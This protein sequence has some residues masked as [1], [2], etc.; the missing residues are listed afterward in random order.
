MY[1]YDYANDEYEL[2]HHHK[3]KHHGLEITPVRQTRKTRRI[4]KANTQSVELPHMEDDTHFRRVIYNAKKNVIRAK[5]KDIEKFVR[6]AKAKYSSVDLKL[7]QQAF[8]TNQLASGVYKVYDEEGYY[9]CTGTLVSGRMYV[10][11]HV[12][13]EDTTKHY[14]ARNHVHSIR[15]EAKDAY[16]V[17]NEVVAFKVNG[18]PSV[19]TNK[20]FKKL[21]DSGI[22][23]IFGFGNG[24]SSTP[25]SIVGFASTLGWCNARTRCGDCTA[26]VLDMNGN[27]VGFWTH[28]N[29]ISFGRFEPVTDE[30][31]LIF[32]DC[33]NLTHVGLDFRFRPLSPSL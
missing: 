16:V 7:G 1:K 15:M 8:N 25:D 26:P 4:L 12:L 29:G 17:N 30:F 20:R 9:R 24:E 6:E 31:F 28:G 27:I 3:L 11:A 2:R 19:F 33:A 22:V 32:K 13:S 21:E 18:I 10:V 23:T 5:A 14:T